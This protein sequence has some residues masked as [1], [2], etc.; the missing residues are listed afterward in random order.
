MGFRA[1]SLPHVLLRN[2]VLGKSLEEVSAP[3]EG[4]AAVSHKM[5]VEVLHLPAPLRGDGMAQSLAYRP[6]RHTERRQ[7]PVWCYDPEVKRARRNETSVTHPPPWFSAFRM[8]DL[9]V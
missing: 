5:V 1:V 3:S 7:R 2:T 4:R 9:A 6:K 8:F